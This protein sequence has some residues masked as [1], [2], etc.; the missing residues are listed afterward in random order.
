MAQ[1]DPAWTRPAFAALT[2]TAAYFI[3]LALRPPTPPKFD[4]EHKKAA[5]DRANSIKH[6]R[7]LMSYRNGLVSIG[8]W[9]ALYILQPLDVLRGLRF[10][11]VP[12]HV[13]NETLLTPNAV[14]VACLSAIC[15]AGYIRT[16]AYAALGKDF[17]FELRRPSRL[18]TSGIYA[19]LQ[20][21]S[22]T[23]SMLAIGGYGFWFM[24]CD[25]VFGTI[26]PDLSKQTQTLCN[27]L[28]PTLH[29]VWVGAGL[30]KRVKIEEKMLQDTFGS[31]WDEWHARTARFVPFLF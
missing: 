25:G 26:L 9:Q 30:L 15:V 16:R 11:P 14:S 18:N 10:A 13:L 23:M 17:T 31:E 27:Y 21:P 28:I 1:I 7:M 2:G 20:H 12:T 8:A 29:A 5:G 6:H 4:D 3:Y 24:R 22:Y 19:Y